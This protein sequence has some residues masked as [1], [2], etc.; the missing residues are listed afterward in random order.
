MGPYHYLAFTCGKRKQPDDYKCK[1]LLSLWGH[2]A[3]WHS[4]VGNRKSKMTTHV[5]SF[6]NYNTVQYNTI[7][8]SPWGSFFR[9]NMNTAKHQTSHMIYLRLKKKK[10]TL[11]RRAREVRNMLKSLGYSIHTPHPQLTQSPTKSLK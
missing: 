6:L 8:L 10:T 9:S 4:R 11:P 7:L 3:T 5:R 1:V 2:T